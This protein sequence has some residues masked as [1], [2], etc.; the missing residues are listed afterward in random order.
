LLNNLPVCHLNGASLILDMLFT[1]KQ[2]SELYSCLGVGSKAALHFASRQSGVGFGSRIVIFTYGIISSPS[3]LIAL[4]S[5]LSDC[6]SNG[7]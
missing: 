1:M 4:K 5:M 7:I 3:Q 6:E 2:S